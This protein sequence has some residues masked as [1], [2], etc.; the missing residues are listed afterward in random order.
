ME[1]CGPREG[2]ISIF[3]RELQRLRLKMRVR[4]RVRVRV[5][6]QEQEQEQ[7]GSR[8][9]VQVPRN[10]GTSGTRQGYSRLHPVKP[11]QV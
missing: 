1:L 11:Q 8:S 7:E 5:Q 4:V 6:E 9:G 3:S 2:D 10:D